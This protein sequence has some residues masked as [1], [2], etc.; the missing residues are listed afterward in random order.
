MVLPGT[1]RVFVRIVIIV[2]PIKNRI[3][4]RPDSRCCRHSNSRMLREVEQGHQVRQ[5]VLGQ[6]DAKLKRPERG[7]PCPPSCP[8]LGRREVKGLGI[9]MAEICRC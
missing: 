6:I 3:R 7:R 2:I 1:F 9:D 4:A 8:S 5:P